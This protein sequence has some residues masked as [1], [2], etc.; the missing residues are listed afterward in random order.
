MRCS[1]WEGGSL[2]PPPPIFLFF[3]KL[4]SRQDGDLE[5]YVLVDAVPIVG[6]FPESSPSRTP[7]DFSLVHHLEV[8]PNHKEEDH[9]LF[10]LFSLPVIEARAR[11]FARF[12]T[13]ATPSLFLLCC[14]FSLF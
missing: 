9:T 1:K 10:S 4:S 2:P 11:A 12:L 14:F 5:V 3:G 13:M 6:N 8:T 7:F